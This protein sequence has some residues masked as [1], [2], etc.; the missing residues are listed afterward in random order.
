MKLRMLPAIAAAFV[1]S[2][3]AI[4]WAA[5]AAVE[6]LRS[7]I[8]ALQSKVASLEA[9]SVTAADVDAKVQKVLEDAERRSQLGGGTMLA[10][11]QNGKFIIQSADGNYLINPNIQF[12]LR[13]IA[14]SVSDDGSG[15]DEIDT[16]F[17]LRRLKLGFAG[18]AI[19]PDLTYN[20]V[21]ATDRKSGNFKLEDAWVRYQIS[22]PW[23]VFGGQFKDFAFH[24]KSVS[25]KR[26][27]AVERSLM[28]ELLAGGH[29]DYVQGIGV[30]WQNETLRAQLAFHDGAKSSNTN[31]EDYT[32]DAV[33]GK[34]SGS[35]FGGTGR[36][37]WM[38]VG[39]SWKQYDDFSALKN[40]ED[41]LVFGAGANLTQAGSA[42]VFYHTVD[43][44]W[45]PQ[46]V[47]GLS[48]YA[49]LVGRSSDDG[50]L[51]TYD[52]GAL[53]QAGYLFTDKWE[54]FGRY[55]VTRYEEVAV[56]AEDTYH[57]IT[58]GV[59]YYLAGHNAKF[60]MDLT[61]LPNGSPAKQDGLGFVGSD[62]SQVI[63]RVQFQLLL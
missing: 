14:N 32:T 50:S 37:E 36:V 43:V 59:N 22:K 1:A 38:A 55:D 40:K 44:Q 56:G 8:N 13:Y 54:V 18:N 10:G 26:Q 12:Q 39:N 62:E 60:T 5:D 29:T 35:H 7:Q 49:A 42:D 53:V 21:W 33:S 46:A 51:S 30:A 17:E 63:G 16:G 57:E 11:Y 4:A 47:R 20:F 25:S 6:D 2:G 52:Y 24:E 3:S 15:D 23:A 61:Y 9:K 48:L 41:L 19:T 31:W 28:N 34:T 27:L 58:T 45:E